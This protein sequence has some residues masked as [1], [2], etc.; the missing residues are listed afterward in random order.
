MAAPELRREVGGAPAPRVAARVSCLAIVA[1]A[2]LAMTCGVYALGG[3]YQRAG[4]PVH[5][6]PTSS[7]SSR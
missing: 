3:R 2:A 1:A 6:A 4:L 7:A 5:P